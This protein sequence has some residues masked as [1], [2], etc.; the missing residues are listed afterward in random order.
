MNKIINGKRYDTDKAKEIGSWESTWDCGSVDYMSET[1]YRKRTGEFFLH[2]ERGMRSA[3]AYRFCDN[4]M[5]SDGSEHIVLLAYEQA[6]GWAEENMTADE[7]EAVFGEVADD[8]GNVPVTLS[9]PA[10]AK[11]KLEAQAAKTG[12]S[13]SAIVARLV[14]EAL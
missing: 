7:Y 3:T 1:L 9:L 12:E 14:S 11:A 5:A 8:A 10:S 13:Q 6:Q 4:K 2:C